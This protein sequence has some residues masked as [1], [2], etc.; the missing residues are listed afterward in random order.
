VCD[1]FRKR[2]YKL[3][4]SNQSILPY[5]Y[6]I[7]YWSL[8]NIKDGIIDLRNKSW[9]PEYVL[10]FNMEWRILVNFTSRFWLGIEYYWICSCPSCMQIL[11]ADLYCTPTSTYCSFL[12]T[13]FYILTLLYTTFIC[14]LRHI[15]IEINHGSQN[16]FWVLTWNG[17]F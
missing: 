7:L 1:I 5:L 12:Y 17:G 9:K 4:S 13:T 8:F 10:S 6:S 16:M 11:H 2:K 14:T 15:R 3:L